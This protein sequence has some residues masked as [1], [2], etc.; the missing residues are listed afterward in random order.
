[1]PDEAIYGLRALGFWHGTLVGGV[2]YSTLYPLFAGAVLS[3]GSLA[4]G[5]ALLK[6][7]QAF[8]MSLAAVPVYVGTHRLARARYALLAA[9]LTV[10]NP[11]LLFS[12]YLMSEVVFY[13]VSACA[14]FAMA[15]AVEQPTLRRQGV[16]LAWIAAAIATRMQAVVLIGVFVL[17][18]LTEAALARRRPR[19]RGLWP[20][21]GLLVVGL[22]AAA[23]TPGVLGAYSTTLSRGYELGPALRLTEYHLAYLIVMVGVAPVVAL[24]LLVV[25]AQRLDRAT[26]SLVAVAL[27]ATVL[28]VVQVGVF[29]SRYAPRLLGRDLAALLP[30]LFAVLAVWLARG[31]PGRRWFAS[32]VVLA[33]LALLVVVPW[34]GLVT[35]GTIPDTPGLA[36]ALRRPWGWSPADVIVATGAVVLVLV[37]FV[38]RGP[39]V[40]LVLLALF[41]ASSVQAA[42]T[43]SGVVARMQASLVGTPRNWIARATSQP[44]TYVYAGDIELWTVYWEQRF[45]NPQIDRA[46]SL[47]PNRIPGPLEQAAI[48]VPA[49]GRLPTPDRYV[50]ADNDLTF[51]GAPVAQ[52]SRG[53]NE[54]GLTLWK[55]DPPA[56]LSTIEHDFKPNGDILGAATV[57]ALDCAG[58][59][60]QLTL[61]PKST[62]RLEID[63]DGKRALVTHIGGLPS[64]SGTVQVPRVH[65]AA[66][67][68]TIIGGALLGSTRIAFEPEEPQRQSSGPTRTSILP[69]LS[70]R[71]R[72]ANAAGA[73]SSPSTIV[74]R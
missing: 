30:V 34:N 7:V 15:R 21:W 51:I 13:P 64:W 5:Y 27:S 33:V 28:V 53:P 23:A 31:A 11:I 68:F 52:Q 26:R 14:L 6:P 9:A 36:L 17:A 22:A 29:A 8:V 39:L 49:D 50:V 67:T 16:A 3:A 61:L 70:P 74:S 62:N 65:A 18:A 20:L 55:L 42:H 72:P 12:G 73:F 45:W 48:A 57:T 71:N 44:V 54:Y 35:G 69:M 2:G 41:T 4:K 47:L 38:P 58:G 19:L 37:R 46:V 63:L 1:M 40:P 32:V 10:A 56:R 25:G 66:C 43:V 60:L 59:E 24:V